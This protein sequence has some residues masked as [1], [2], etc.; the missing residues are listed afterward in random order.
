MVWNHVENGHWMPSQLTR[1]LDLTGG[2]P[3]G[4]ATANRLKYLAIE[5]ETWSNLIGCS[6][7]LI[8]L[9]KNGGIGK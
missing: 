9:H 8:L 7:F 4:D 5:R 2:V 3:C 6:A 1:P